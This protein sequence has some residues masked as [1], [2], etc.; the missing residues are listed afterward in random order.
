MDDKIILSQDEEEGIAKLKGVLI[1]CAEYEL[2]IYFKKCQFL[3][4]FTFD[5]ES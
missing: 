1:V 3:K 2:K 4:K 5:F